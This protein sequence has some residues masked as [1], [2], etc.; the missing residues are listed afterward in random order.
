LLHGE[1][2]QAVEEMKFQV[3]DKEH[4]ETGTNQTRTANVLIATREVIGEL[5]IGIV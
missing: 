1:R 3:S 5:F 4:C 2:F